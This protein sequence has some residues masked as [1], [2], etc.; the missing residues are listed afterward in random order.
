VGEQEI[1]S[2]TAVLRNMQTR[3]QIA[4]SLSNIVEEMRSHVKL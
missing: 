1:T 2:Q 4:V 3:E